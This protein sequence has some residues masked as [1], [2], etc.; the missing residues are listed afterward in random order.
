M[1]PVEFSC[2]QIKVYM[3]ILRSVKCVVKCVLYIMCCVANVCVLVY[4]PLIETLLHSPTIGF[5][6]NSTLYL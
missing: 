1:A 6:K 4:D 5:F 2:K 3:C